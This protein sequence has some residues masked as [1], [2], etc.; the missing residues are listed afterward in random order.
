MSN[1][2]SN[3]FATKFKGIL[4]KNLEKRISKK[5]GLQNSSG[6]ALN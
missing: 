4:K 5:L 3:E 1:A 6:G 2:K